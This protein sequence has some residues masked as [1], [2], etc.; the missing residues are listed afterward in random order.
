MNI[1]PFK[2]IQP[3]LSPPGL[4][5]MHHGLFAILCQLTFIL[6]HTKMHAETVM[7]ASLSVRFF[8]M[9]EHSLMSL[10]ILF[11]G[12]YLIERALIESKKE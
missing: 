10:V 2:N 9:L 8:P 7:N 3:K 12:V 1:F 4:F 11:M 6:L 5:L